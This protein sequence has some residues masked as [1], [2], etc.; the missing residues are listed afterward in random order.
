MNAKRRAA[1]LLLGVL[2]AACGSTPTSTPS[3]AATHA[4]PTA[5]PAASASTT[6]PTA[7]TPATPDTVALVP[8]SVAVTVA[9]SL[10]L[11]SKPEVNTASEI[12]K[13]SLSEGDQVFVVDG[14][15]RASGYDWYDVRP[16][17]AR[18]PSWGWVAAA[19][20][21][22]EPWL[23]PGVA[24]CPPTPTTFAQLTALTDGQRLACFS[25]VP[26]TVRARIVRFVGS[27]DP[28]YS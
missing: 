11:R 1:S 24:T 13:P 27:V 23:V 14:P 18:L 20:R 17:S 22:D 12:F 28:G 2:L 4:A 10:V 21:S 26:I 15:V 25:R 19:S 7:G 16:L 6:T 8:D 3:P 9:T 5:S